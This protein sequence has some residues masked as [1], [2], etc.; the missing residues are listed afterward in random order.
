MPFS[1][2]L[3]GLLNNFC[4]KMVKNIKSKFYKNKV[5]AAVKRFY[6]N[7]QPSKGLKG[8]QLIHDNAYA[9]KS[10]TVEPLLQQEKVIQ[11]E[12]LPY[13]PDLRPCDFFSI[14]ILLKKML[15]D[16]CYSI[17]FEVPLVLQFFS[18]STEGK[19][20]LLCSI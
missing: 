4:V 3:V 17:G 20:R 11:L 12:H 6:Q 14:S 9:H 2:I 16:K 15:T 19:G 7:K 13:S 8:I 5:L 1:S 10:P 18:D